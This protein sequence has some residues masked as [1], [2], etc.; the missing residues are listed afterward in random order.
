MLLKQGNIK[1]CGYYEVSPVALEALDTRALHFALTAR[2][3][4]SFSA[5][6][7]WN[8]LPINIRAIDKRAR[9]VAEVRALMMG[10][11]GV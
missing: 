4:S 9:F 8:A 11:Q 1:I 10:A 5:C 2:L 6:R 3:L 7:L